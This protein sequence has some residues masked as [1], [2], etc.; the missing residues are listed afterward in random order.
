LIYL[1]ETQLRAIHPYLTAGSRLHHLP[2]PVQR[3]PSPRIRAE[4]NDLYL[5][6][7]RLSPEK[8]GELAAKAARAAGARIAFAGE[9]ESRGAILAANPDAQMLGWLAPEELARW[10]AKARCLV[11]PS[12]WYEGYPMSVVEAMQAG[13]PILASDRSAAAEVVRHGT[14]GLH[15]KTGSLQAWIEAFRALTDR[16]QVSRYS[17]SSFEASRH[18]LDPEGY[19][20][21]LLSIYEQAS[22]AQASER[23]GRA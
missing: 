19:R 15:V 3:T 11:F 14:D 8:G 6:V 7:G 16:E 18:F 5:F 13:L 9:G 20:A 22:R 12:L 23:L 21:K 17:Q 1:T 10:M 4:V 2:N